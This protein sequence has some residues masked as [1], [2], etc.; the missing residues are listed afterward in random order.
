MASNPSGAK[1]SREMLENQIR[2]LR[3]DN[4]I[5]RRQVLEAKSHADA[6]ERHLIHLR[7]RSQQRRKNKEQLVSARDWVKIAQYVT[8]VLTLILGVYAGVPDFINSSTFDNFPKMF[9]YYFVWKVNEKLCGLIVGCVGFLISIPAQRTFPA[10]IRVFRFL[11][12]SSW[13]RSGTD[14]IFPVQFRL[15]SAKIVPESRRAVPEP[16]KIPTD[17]VAGMIDL[18]TSH[19]YM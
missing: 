15:E 19:V 1:L 12:T 2:A 13:K 11:Q 18:G 6:Q 17:P 5:L 8:G 3:V 14:R 4:A 7:H 10:P 16:T 9:R